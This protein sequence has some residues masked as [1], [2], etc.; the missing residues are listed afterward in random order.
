MK[1]TF[2][3][4]KPTGRYRSFYRPDIYIKHNRLKIGSI[5]ADE[6]YVIR[7]TVKREP[8]KAEPAPFRWIT[9]AYKSKTLEESKRYAE[10]NLE[11]II[12]KYCLVIHHLEDDIKTS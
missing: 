10:E 7:V 8:T 12:N 11:R 9:L 6:P 3:T 4:H 5:E 1:L 2:K